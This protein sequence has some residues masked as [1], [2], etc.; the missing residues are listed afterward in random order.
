MVVAWIESGALNCFIFVDTHRNNPMKIKYFLITL[1]F[2]LCANAN[3]EWFLRGTHNNWAATQMAV[4]GTNTMQLNNVVFA[5]AGNIKFDRFGDW[6]ES[7][8]V[9]GKG[10]TNIAVAA[11]AWN[12]KFFTDTK[13]W[14]I[15]RA[16]T[17]SSVSSS[18]AG[19][20][21]IGSSKASSSI[22]SSSKASISSTSKANSSASSI[23]GT[24]Y[25]LRGTHNGWAEG[26]LFTAVAGSTTNMEICRNFLTSATITQ[27]RFRVDP[28]G[29][30]GTDAFPAAD[31]AASG[32]TKIVINRSTKALVS[33]TKGMGSNCTLA[34][35][36]SSSSKSSVSSKSAASSA[37]SS[38]KS[39]SSQTSSS[40]KS[41]S[42]V[43]S[44][45]D[46][47]RARTMYF[48]FVDRFANG[49]TNN[50]N[51]NNPKSTSIMKATGGA[52][53]WVKYWG[54]DIEG[55]ISKLDYLQSLGVT[56]IWVTPLMDNV[57]T[58]SN[59]GYHGYWAK[60]FYEVDEHLGNW[61]DRKSVV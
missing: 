31:M 10:G 59:G 42:S 17:S 41:S 53:D 35:S 33:V 60:D 45:G 11:G 18:K 39:N 32:W 22:V 15:T 19:S 58:G 24:K 30:W 40:S 13:N 26:D 51:G 27:P 46:D 12:I 57:D 23:A 43:S 25:H 61:A 54:G 14:S 21:V 8:G 44:I 36:V 3:A 5:A 7:Y 9:G 20:S 50:D 56:A 34:S 4:G 49:N 2:S 1:L 52:T 37:K 48:V 55:L 38:A 16:A 47:F 28:N 6:K 29:G